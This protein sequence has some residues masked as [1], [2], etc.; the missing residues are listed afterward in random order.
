MIHI[1]EL[2]RQRMEDREASPKPGA[3]GNMREL[4]DKQM[5][6]AQAATNWRRVIGYF[7]GVL[8]FASASVGGYSLYSDQLQSESGT[9]SSALLA[10]NTGLG[11]GVSGAGNIDAATPTPGSVPTES[12]AG[13]AIGANGSGTHENGIAGAQHRTSGKGSG[14]AVSGS[15]QLNNNRDNTGYP[16]TDNRS[17]NSIGSTV[18]HNK[19]V[20]SASAAQ[21]RQVA[22][23]API[24]S[25][26]RPE[27]IAQ[28]TFQDN[29]T[30]ATSAPVYTASAAAPASSP[31]SPRVATTPSVSA[32][33]AGI[34]A[35]PRP[36]SMP[37]PAPASATN[38]RQA[39]TSDAP[40]PLEVLSASGVAA[41]PP[42]PALRVMDTVRRIEI[43]TRRAFVAGTRRPVYRLD[44]LP[45]EYAI[46]ERFVPIATA[47]PAIAMNTPSGPA[48]KAGSRPKPPA[49]ATAPVAA[50]AAKGAD[51]VVVPGSAAP[52]SASEA[53]NAANEVAAKLSGSKLGF[54]RSL[55]LDERVE[56]AKASLQSIQLYP[57][58]LAGINGTMFTPNSLGGFQL[59]LTSLIAI[60]DNWSVLGELKYIH[61]FNTGS[62]LR[63]DY[64]RIDEATKRVIEIDQKNYNEYTWKESG[65]DHYFN[66]ETIQTIELPIAIRYNSNR[67][68]AQSGLNFVSSRPISAREVTNV[69]TTSTSRR[70]VLPESSTLNPTPLNSQPNVQM[71]DF[72][73]RLGVGYVFGAGYMFT[74]SVYMDVRMAQ[75][76]WHNA[77]TPGSRQIARDLLG[78]P[79]FQLSVGYRFG[80]G[81]QER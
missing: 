54:W 32:A 25:G 31:R 5:P 2:F 59:G 22:G 57:G 70:E 24:V 3:W 7:T 14:A 12:A 50:S 16:N 58:I 79:S 15:S 67:F 27:A 30:T 73:S 60:N 19:H 46:V 1:D 68:F 74:P 43:V 37:N 21:N 69:P 45:A 66:Y 38:R 51:D 53:V 63:D 10:S 35:D 81:K 52:A 33:P 11:Q 8:L 23:A 56:A 49:G 72:G 62:T 18:S 13:S 48:S 34:T 17:A 65:V 78:R 77:G 64:L 29:N 42:A 41:K 36:S 28:S 80:T 76:F 71:A 55:R 75:S 26:N 61:R 9:V 6:V 47:A 20:A 40:A 44:T 39:Q 4:L